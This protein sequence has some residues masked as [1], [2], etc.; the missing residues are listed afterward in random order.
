MGT[1]VD[2]KSV[3]CYNEAGRP[4]FEDA[5]LSFSG[6]ERVLI[7]AP[8]ASG[9]S[10]LIRMLAGLSMPDKGTVSVFGEDIVSL[11]KDGLNK[12][13]QRMGFVFHDSVLISNLKVIENVALPLIYHRAALSYEDAMQEAAMLLE[14]T[15]FRGDLWGLPGVLPLYAKKEIALARALVLRPEII[16][17]ENLWEGLTDTEKTGLSS[18]LLQY[19]ESNPG[20]LLVFTALS[21]ADA[22]HVRP[23][24]VIR[25]E[26]SRI[27][28]EL[29]A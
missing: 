7:I 20:G 9:K 10:V 18:L 22:P 11:T 1:L 5:N 15:G 16:V 3:S 8:V 17:C 27:S 25:I 2:I 4:L 21:D 28:E 24:R 12:L 26:G 13:R 23:H 19:H 29:R 14:R 6:G